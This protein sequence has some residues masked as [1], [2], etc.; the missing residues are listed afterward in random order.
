MTVMNVA[1]PFVSRLTRGTGGDPDREIPRPDVRPSGDAEDT[2][3]VAAIANGDASA[4]DQLYVRYRRVTFAAAY[5]VAQEPSAS[6]DIVHDAFLKVWRS[7]ATFSPGHG[8]VRSWLQAIVRNVAIDHLRARRKTLPASTLDHLELSPLGDGSQEDIATTVARAADA[9]LL[10][11]ALGALPPA[12]RQA[13]ELAFFGGLSHGEI[14]ARTGTPL[15]TVKGRVR[16]GLRRL[17]H[18]LRELAPAAAMPVG[19]PLPA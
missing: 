4:L 2:A 18:D 14:A 9:R 1:T 10:H 19:A 5:A 13:V 15:G 7:A 16:L 12:Q 6:D 11:S 17:R 3:L 8:S